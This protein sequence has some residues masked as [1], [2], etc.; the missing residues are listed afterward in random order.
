MGGGVTVRDQRSVV[1]RLGWTW[2]E[3]VTVQTP[4]LGPYTGKTDGQK[5]SY[6]SNQSD[7]QGSDQYRPNIEPENNT[8]G[9][10]TDH[11]GETKDVNSLSDYF[12]YC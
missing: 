2:I 11:R 5:T 3:T 8:V 12:Y 7:V 1:P 9:V 4:R 6:I 10:E